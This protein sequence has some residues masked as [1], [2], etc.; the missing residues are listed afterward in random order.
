MKKQDRTLSRID[1]I[2]KEYARQ[3]DKKLKHH[4]NK[5]NNNMDFLIAFN[6]D[7]INNNELAN[8]ISK[9]GVISLSLFI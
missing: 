8:I 3:A 5:K 7:F 1:K 2:G 4:Y 9:S 6:Y